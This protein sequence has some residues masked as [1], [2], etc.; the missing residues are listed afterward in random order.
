MTG[1]ALFLYHGAVSHRRLKP[2]GHRFAYKVF[3]ILIDIDRIDEAAET[4]RWFSRN[5]FNLFSFHDADHAFEDLKSVSESVRALLRANGYSGDGRIELLCY[6]RVL[7]FVFNPLSIF[8]CRDGQ[9]RLEAVI[10]EVRNT[11]G[12]RHS[13]LIPADGDAEVIRQSADKVFHVSPFMD[14]DHIYDFRLTPPGKSLSVFI[15][16]SDA[17]GPIFNAAFAGAAEEASDAAWMKA[18]F[19]YPLMT[20][21]IVAAIHFEAGR[22]FMKG[23]RL[24]GR[25]TEPAAPVSA[26]KRAKTVRRAA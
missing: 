12:G 26:L 19:R 13:Y 2:V 16:Q 20:L 4:S 9:G 21:K 15:H 8:Y 11:F 5:R 3:S 6:P 25:G 7:G 14:M 10:Y 17:Q 1:A 18:F 24:K 22:L 23:L